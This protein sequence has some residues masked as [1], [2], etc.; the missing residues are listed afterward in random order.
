MVLIEF[1]CAERASGLGT[2]REFVEGLTVSIQIE[3]NCGSRER[4]KF[5][6][7]L[8]WNRWRRGIRNSI[9]FIHVTNDKL[10]TPAGREL[11]CHRCK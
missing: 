3:G 10:P 4:A 7:N 5:R 9:S 2:V 1:C 11:H 8:L 6:R